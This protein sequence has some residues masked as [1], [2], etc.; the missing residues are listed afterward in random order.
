[1]KMDEINLLDGFTCNSYQLPNTRHH[2]LLLF[3]FISDGQFQTLHSIQ[4]VV[5]KIDRENENQTEVE[6]QNIFQ[7][8]INY[9]NDP[10]KP[11]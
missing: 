10:L 11:T 1:M 2:T 9:S 7:M 5:T 4:K 3:Y 8:A 6:I